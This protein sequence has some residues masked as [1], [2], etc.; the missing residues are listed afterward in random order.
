MACPSI[1]L[2]IASS[3]DGKIALENGQSKWITGEEARLDGRR[4]RA[5]HDAIAIG[6]NTAIEDNP[7]L[8]TRI[9]GA[10]DPVRIIF[11]SRARLPL[12]SNLVQ[13]AEQTPT[14][15]IT[16]NDSENSRALAEQGVII[17]FAGATSQGYVDINI[18]MDMLGHHG[19]KTLLIEGG[20]TLAASFIKA[21]LVDVIEWYRAPIIMG[22]D[23][24]N[25]IGDLGL[26]AMTFVHKFNR[27]EFKEMGADIYERYE[28]VRD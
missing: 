28:R 20:G 12:G 17:L 27:I 26:E 7:K 13:T 1:T 22:G 6:V 10:L 4:L 9:E 8:T 19:I 23:G 21:G 14:Y 18:A 2:K 15:V 16:A 11:D 24:R 5:V 3:L 25:A